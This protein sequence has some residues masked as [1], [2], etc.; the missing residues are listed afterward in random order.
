MIWN[1]LFVFEGQKTS[2]KYQKPISLLQKNTFYIVR[3]VHRK[4]WA[5]EVTQVVQKSGGWKIN[6]RKMQL[7]LLVL[8]VSGLNLV[9]HNCDDHFKSKSGLESLFWQRLIEKSRKMMHFRKNLG[10]NPPTTH[11]FS[12]FWAQTGKYRVF[13]SFEIKT[14]PKDPHLVMHERKNLEN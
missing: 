2:K 9:N 7:K 8:L 13:P 12:R 5:S 3:S 14:W 4:F 1:D 10:S 11:L 6:N